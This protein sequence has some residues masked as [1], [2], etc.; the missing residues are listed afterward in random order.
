MATKKQP[1]TT[2]IENCNFTNTSAANE[3]T[4]AAVEALAMAVTENAR[5]IQAIANALKGSSATMETAIK[6][7][8]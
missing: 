4:R 7:G 3:H 8:E 6:I 5:A 1:S 2:T